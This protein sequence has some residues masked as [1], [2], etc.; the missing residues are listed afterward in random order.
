MIFFILPNH[1]ESY[2]FDSLN[3]KLKHKGVEV[4]INYIV[5]R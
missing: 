3:V 4:N 2:R 5:K 1:E